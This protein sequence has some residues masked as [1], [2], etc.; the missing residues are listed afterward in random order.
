MHKQPLG[1]L[2]AVS[3]KTNCL[4]FD[5]FSDIL[6]LLFSKITSC[7]GNFTFKNLVGCDIENTILRMSQRQ[8]VVTDETTKNTK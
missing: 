2:S 5:A 6:F 3:Q 4:V 1:D 7:I 8:R